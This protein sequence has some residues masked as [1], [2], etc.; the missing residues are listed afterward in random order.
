MK[1]FTEQTNT[2]MTKSERMIGFQAR[3]H[4]RIVKRTLE[5]KTQQSESETKL[6]TMEMHKNSLGISFVAVSVLTVL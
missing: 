3:R 1:S 2:G 6:L 4:Y 5:F